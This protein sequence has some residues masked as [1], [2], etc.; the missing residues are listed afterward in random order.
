MDRP[1]ATRFAIGAIHEFTF[2]S[3]APPTDRTDARTDACV[4]CLAVE[5][6]EIGTHFQSEA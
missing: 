3:I 4:Y 2:A 6:G 1:K 5:N